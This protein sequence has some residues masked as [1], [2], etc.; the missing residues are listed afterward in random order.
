[1][2]GF[3][4]LKFSRHGAI[5]AIIQDANNGEVLGTGY[6]NKEALRRTVESGKTHLWSRSRDKVWMKGKHSG[7]TQTVRAIFADCDGDVLLLKVEQDGAA[8][9]QGY[10]SCFHRQLQIGNRWEVVAERIAEPRTRQV[11]HRKTH[12]Q[13]R[14]DRHRRP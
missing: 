7:H 11:G 10:R 5:R 13:H 1:M 9:R 14:S 12:R 2:Q 3:D 6:M 8:C 4:D